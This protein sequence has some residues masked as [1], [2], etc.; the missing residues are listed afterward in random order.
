MQAI[1]VYD[2]ILKINALNV[3]LSSWNFIPLLIE[4]LMTYTEKI[5][6]WSFSVEDKS[7]IEDFSKVVL[8]R[9]TLGNERFFELTATETF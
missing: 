9:D 3:F 1:N 6:I 5:N 2:Y 7:E 8:V 4:D